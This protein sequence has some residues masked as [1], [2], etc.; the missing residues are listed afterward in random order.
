MHFQR[1]CIRLL[2]CVLP[3]CQ[4][5]RRLTLR[6]AEDDEELLFSFGFF[7][8]LVERFVERRVALV[9]DVDEVPCSTVVLSAPAAKASRASRAAMISSREGTQSLFS[10]ESSR[11]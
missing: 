7:T 5:W 1:R 4:R 11:A 10:N 6:V 9:V 8:F 3:D 2:F